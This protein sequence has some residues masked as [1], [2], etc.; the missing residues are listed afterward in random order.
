MLVQLESV[1]HHAAQYIFQDYKRASSVTNMLH[2][3]EWPTLEQR[4]VM[5]H[6]TMMLKIINGLID[7]PVEPYEQ[8]FEGHNFRCFHG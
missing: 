2:T 4:R 1:Q 8:I 6:T 3:L 5:C 7:I